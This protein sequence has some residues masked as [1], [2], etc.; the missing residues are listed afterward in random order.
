M[1]I[2]PSNKLDLLCNLLGITVDILHDVA[3]G[4][5][6]GLTNLI[7]NGHR[8]FL[9]AVQLS[10]GVGGDFAAFSALLGCNVV[11]QHISK[12]RFIADHIVTPCQY[13]NP[14]FHSTG[15]ILKAQ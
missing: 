14:I 13:N 7:E 2:K 4:Y 12:Q 8:H 3:V 6:K 1:H 5:S 15:V 10:P 11:F 9:V